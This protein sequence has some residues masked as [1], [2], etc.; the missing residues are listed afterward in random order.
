TANAS[1]KR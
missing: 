1:Q